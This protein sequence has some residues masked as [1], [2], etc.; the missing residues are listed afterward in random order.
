M[1]KILIGIFILVALAI[2]ALSGVTYLEGLGEHDDTY[3]THEHD[4]NGNHVDGE[5]VTAIDANTINYLG[6]YTILDAEHGTEVT[7]TVDEAAGTRTM[8]SNT[9]PNHDIGE[10]P[11]P[12]NPNTLSAQDRTNVFP[13]EPILTDEGRFARQA[14]MALNGVKFEPQTAERLTC[15]T[16]E[17]Y[18]V[19][20]LEGYLDFGV[21]SNNAH[22]QPTGEYHYHGVAQNLVNS[23]DQGDEPIHAGFAQDG[24]LIYYSK[25]GAYTPSMQLKTT[26]RT[27]AN[28]VYERPGVSIDEDF[29]GTA[30]D[31]SFVSDWEYVDGSGN[32]DE[33]NGTEINGQ[34]AYVITNEYP[35]I[36]RCLKGEVAAG[37]R[38]GQGDPSAVPPPTR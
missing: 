16:G 30:P 1:K 34:Y 36:P 17:V 6:S 11:N 7:V 24:F 8:V 33:C 13:L 12:G 18:S 38:G 15:A 29:A 28:C 21:D 14:G 19:E 9:L 31:G 22:V 4:E 23:F 27:G 20:A 26:P 32:L 37:E 10:F 25:T 2:A 3:A 5:G 35:Y